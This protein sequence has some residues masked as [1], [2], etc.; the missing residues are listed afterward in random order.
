MRDTGDSKLE[1]RLESLEKTIK[2]FHRDNSN[3]SMAQLRQQKDMNDRGAR[4]D[5]GDH[6]AVGND[7]KIP[8]F[9][10]LLYD[11]ESAST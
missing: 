6:S 11:T 3:I 7:E 9:T 4:H 10:Q 1:K 2:D 8:M 5:R